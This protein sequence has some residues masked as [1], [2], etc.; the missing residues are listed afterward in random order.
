[1]HTKTPP[2][3]VGLGSIV[4]IHLPLTSSQIS[5]TTK[6]SAPRLSRGLHRQRS[7]LCP[8]FDYLVLLT[9][10]RNT[11]CL[12]DVSADLYRIDE[13]ASCTL[14]RASRGLI[15]VEAYSPFLCHR[16]VLKFRLRRNAPRRDF[17]AVCTGSGRYSALCS[18]ISSYSLPFVIL[19]VSQIKTLPS[20]ATG[21]CRVFIL[22]RH[23]G[24]RVQILLQ[25]SVHIHILLK[26]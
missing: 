12:T 15:H 18:T 21:S 25:T 20:S 7:I 19:R 17:H 11:S 13:R 24:Y 14:C 26:V 23:R 4:F 22:F 10:V 16:Q 3:S 6:R 9:P 2:F 5:S 8:L 1:M